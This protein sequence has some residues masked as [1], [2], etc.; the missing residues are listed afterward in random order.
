MVLDCLEAFVG[1]GFRDEEA[2][3]P[4]VGDHVVEDAEHCGCLCF[5]FGEGDGLGREF[6][7]IECEG[8]GLL[9]RR[10]SEV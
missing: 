9:T 2:H 7:G 5:L 1:L 4:G 3:G 6:D 10:C 8:F